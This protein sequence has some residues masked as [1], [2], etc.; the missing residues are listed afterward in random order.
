MKKIVNDVEIE[1]PIEGSV[2]GE[3][4]KIDAVPEALRVQLNSDSTVVTIQDFEGKN[5]PIWFADNQI[6]EF[7]LKGI[8]FIGNVVSADV[9]Y[10]V[11]DETEYVTPEGAVE[12]HTSTV[13]GG[14]NCTHASKIVL[15]GKGLG[16]DFC[17]AMEALRAE[18]APSTGS[19]SQRT[20]NFNRLKPTVDG[21]PTLIAEL[22]AK[23]DRASSTV[24]AQYEE[25]IAEL[26]AELAAAT[27]APMSET[28]KIAGGT[29]AGGRKPRS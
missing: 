29:Q 2:V 5:H 11:A 24:K 7:G 26:E 16:M 27:A 21:L 17:N 19:A 28:D 12:Y 23:R 4:V 13:T 9:E 22:K 20:V 18:H 1:A 3:I 14:R 10:R 25:K 15:L 6:A 8:L